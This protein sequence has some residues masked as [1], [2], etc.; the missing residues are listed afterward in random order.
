MACPTWR[1]VEEEFKQAKSKAKLNSH[2]A[3][4]FNPISRPLHYTMGKIECRQ[5]IED[6][7]LGFYLGN[8]IKYICRAPYKGSA[9]QDLRK[10]IQYLEFEVESLTRQLK[11]DPVQEPGTQRC[12]HDAN[13]SGEGTSGLDLPEERVQRSENSKGS[14]CRLRLDGS[15][16]SDE[17]ESILAR[18]RSRA[19]GTYKT[20][21]QT[22]RRRK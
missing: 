9:I 14:E 6:W 12:P 22:T 16:H 13:S 8:A 3:P 10:A 5:V 2:S 19:H 20:T 4:E 18:L 11:S 1:Q 15:D 21:A 7:N 17:T